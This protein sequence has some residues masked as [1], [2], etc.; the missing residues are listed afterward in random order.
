MLCLVLRTSGVRARSLFRIRHMSEA[1]TFDIA[2]RKYNKCSCCDI[3]TCSFQCF[4]YLCNHFTFLR[5]RRL[6]V[7]Y[8][9]WCSQMANG[10]MVEAEQ[11]LITRTMFVFEHSSVTCGLSLAHSSGHL[12]RSLGFEEMMRRGGGGF[13]KQ[14]WTL[15]AHAIAYPINWFS[16]FEWFILLYTILY[17]IYL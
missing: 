16:L 12:W 8:E 7:F 11:H 5:R 13:D 6:V 14:H 1:F 4:S 17:I 9:L 15:P 10:G 2:V 3:G